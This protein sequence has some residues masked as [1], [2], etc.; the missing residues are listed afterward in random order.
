M[1]VF[2]LSKRGQNILGDGIPA[3]FTNIEKCGQDPY[4]E[5][6][7]TNGCIQLAMAENKTNIPMIREKL[8]SDCQIFPKEWCMEGYGKTMY[9]LPH[10][11]EEVRLFLESKTISFQIFTK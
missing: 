2:M 5:N 10:F 9:G 7:N 1:P 3:Y 6:S 11:R 4:D 8:A